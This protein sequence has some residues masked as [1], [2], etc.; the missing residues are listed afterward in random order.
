MIYGLPNT[1]CAFLDLSQRN[2]DGHFDKYFAFLVPCTVILLRATYAMLAKDVSASAGSF[3][4][5]LV[6]FEGVW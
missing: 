3:T 4:L 5:D 6:C 2:V 1:T